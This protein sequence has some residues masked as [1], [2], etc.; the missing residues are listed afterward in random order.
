MFY[1]EVCGTIN[2]HQ[3]V[4][5]ELADEGRRDLQ[6]KRMAKLVKG[7]WETEW[8]IQTGVPGDEKF[9]AVAT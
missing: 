5:G 6:L 2:L 4:Y 1:G 8:G 7:Q 9:P 3:V